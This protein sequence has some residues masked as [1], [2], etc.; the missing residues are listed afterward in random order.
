MG[1]GRSPRRHGRVI[2]GVVGLDVGAVV[3]VGRG[4]G[5]GPLLGG[6]GVAV[7]VIVS[8]NGE[9]FSFISRAV[10]RGRHI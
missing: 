6:G 2:V 10:F 1:K 3:V 7:A 8:V 4:G 9:W 5:A